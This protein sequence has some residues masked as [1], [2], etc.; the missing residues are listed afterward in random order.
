[1]SQTTNSNHEAAAQQSNPTG[2]IN[3]SVSTDTNEKAVNAGGSF[4]ATPTSSTQVLTNLADNSYMSAATLPD[5]P[6]DKQEVTDPAGDEET[7]TVNTINPVVVAMLFELLG[8]ATSSAFYMSNDKRVAALEEALN[9]PV[10]DDKSFQQFFNHSSKDLEGE[11]Y[12]NARK[13]GGTPVEVTNLQIMAE[14]KARYFAKH[15]KQPIVNE[16]YEV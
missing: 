16:E 8:K 5:A 4:G 3:N 9:I 2:T 11:A 7:S 10:S 6:A 15:K 14:A 12:R 1:M 13:S